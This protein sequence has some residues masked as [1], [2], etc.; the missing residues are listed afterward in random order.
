M[1]ASDVVPGV[2]GGT[3]AFITGIYERLLDAISSI[4]LDKLK[5]L[6]RGEFRT[7]AKETDL[8]F[9]LT[10]L[11]GIVT[12]I[13]TVLRL[14]LYLLEAHPVLL[15]SFFFGLI[16]ASVVLIRRE[17]TR[18]NTVVIGFLI[19]GVLVAYYITSITT[20][21]E[22]DPALWFVFLSG[23]IAI[24][25]MILPGISGAFILLL[26]GSY[27]YIAGS[28]KSL[29]DA[30]VNR[31]WELAF[32][33][34][35]VIGTFGAGALVGLASFSRLLSWLFDHHPNKVIALLIGFLIGSLNKIWPWKYV[36]RQID[37]SHIIQAN[38]NPLEY[39][40]Q[41]GEDPQI[42]LALVFVFIGFALVYFFDKFFA[43][44]KTS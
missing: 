41:T 38:S 26:M 34:L 30:L 2:S 29:T 28:V 24:C 10:L 43:P 20:I 33:F 42:V 4:N 18:W 13:A 31:E 37:E 16:I 39:A 40:A 21:S 22:G 44:K 15:W 27:F 12:A 11:A 9:L 19:V 5:L 25:A 23:A 7:F 14:I 35:T 6:I 3:I 36:V 17:I 1:G 32:G 8:G